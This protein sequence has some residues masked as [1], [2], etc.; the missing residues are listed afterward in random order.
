MKTKLQQPTETKLFKTL[1]EDI[2]ALMKMYD[3]TKQK[4]EQEFGSATGHDTWFASKLGV[5][6][7]RERA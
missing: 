5:D 1:A 7:K 4:Y 2:L 6:L 3:E